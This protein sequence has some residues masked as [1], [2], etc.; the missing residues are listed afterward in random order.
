MSNTFLTIQMITREALRILENS[1]SFTKGVS[2]EY[3][4]KFGVSGAKIGDTLNIRK[5]VRY[6]GRSGTALSVENLTETSVPLQLS[7]QFGVDFTFT[8]KDLALSID[9]F[10][11]RFIRPAV[12]TIA[13]KIDSD[14]L[15]LFSKVY[16][17]VGTPGTAAS[18]LR[19][20]LDA[21]AKL[22]NEGTPRDDQRS[23]VIDPLTQAAVVDNL[24]GLFQSSTQI[25]DQY[26]RGQMGTAAGFD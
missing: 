7:T 12:A 16:N 21:G 25:S 8:T 5:P 11:K 24:K 22:D 26:R 17:A 14:G 1:L 6:V 23:I 15:A 3:D 19:T 20:Y 4:D 13:N 2:R 18:T 9:D 10:S